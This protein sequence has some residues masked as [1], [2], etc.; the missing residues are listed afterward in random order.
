MLTLDDLKRRFEGLTEDMRNKY[1]MD[2][3]EYYFEITE[4]GRKEEAKDSYKEYYC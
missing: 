2:I 4:K 1:P 3:P